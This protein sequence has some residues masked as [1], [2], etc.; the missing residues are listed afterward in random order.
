VCT[1]LSRISIGD[2]P[3]RIIYIDKNLTEEVAKKCQQS[4]NNKY[5]LPVLKYDANEDTLVA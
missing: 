3:S 1:T 4:K 5:E 2:K